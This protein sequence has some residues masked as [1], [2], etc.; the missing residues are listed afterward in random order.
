MSIIE[1]IGRVRYGRQLRAFGNR[2]GVPFKVLDPMI[3][4]MKVFL[5]P[6][7]YFSRKRMAK[8][9]LRE[10]EVPLKIPRDK[11]CAA[12]KNGT[13]PDTDKVVTACR[14]IFDEESPKVD[15]ESDP[16]SKFRQNLLS[17][18]QMKKHPEVLDFALSKP[19][20]STVVDYL[21]AVP[22]IAQI[23]LWW[24]PVNDLMEGSQYHHVDQIDTTHLK[25]ALLIKE[26]GPEDGPLS[27][28]PAD[29]TAAVFPK[30]SK[31]TRYDRVTDEE[32]YQYCSEDELVQ[33]VGQPGDGG[34]ADL[35]R[36]FHYGGRA[37]KGE[38]LFLVIQYVSYHCVKETYDAPWQE[39]ADRMRPDRSSEMEQALL[40]L[41]PNFEAHLAS[42]Y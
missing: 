42:E 28:L 31:K 6:G 26:M 4:L 27:V 24:T 15:F 2:M 29:V 38:R 33:V 34:I 1:K 37:R 32:M 30:L 18:E 5:Y 23:Q 12:F 19:V 3:K 22:T 21:G 20:L 9:L 25:L 10:Q 8:N 16:R 35:S 14:E 11:G 41:P 40:H 36:C 13:F 17:E 39:T 7:E